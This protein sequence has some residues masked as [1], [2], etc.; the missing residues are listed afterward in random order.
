MTGARSSKAAGIA[1]V[2]INALDDIA[3]LRRGVVESDP[4]LPHREPPRDK[5]KAKSCGE[6]FGLGLTLVKRG[7]E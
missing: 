6:I 7:T 2:A 5:K 1:V 3:H 4:I